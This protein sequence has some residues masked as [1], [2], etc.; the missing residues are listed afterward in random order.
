MLDF[1]CVTNGWSFAHLYA[2]ILIILLIHVYIVSYL[3][4]QMREREHAL[5]HRV[6][7]FESVALCVCVCVLSDFNIATVATPPHMQYRCK[8]WNMIFA[9]HIFCYNIKLTSLLRYIIVAHTLLPSLLCV[10]CLAHTIPHMHT[11]IARNNSFNNTL[12]TVYVVEFY[13]HIHN[14]SPFRFIAVA[15]GRHN[16]FMS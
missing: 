9:A 7:V 11:F 12:F 14:F 2:F 13:S 8:K 5:L 15:C 4:A 1:V 16:L 3:R 10:C 6:C